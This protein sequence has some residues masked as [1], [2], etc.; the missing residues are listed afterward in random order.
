[1]D[2]THQASR[3]HV[4]ER[5]LLSPLRELDAGT[6]PVA[7]GK[8]ANLGELI[9][10]GFP[11]PDGFCLTTGAYGELAAAAGLTDVLVRLA[12]LA[13]AAVDGAA[14]LASQARERILATPVPAATAAAVRAAYRELGEPSVAVRSSATAEDLPSASFAGQ[15]DT[16]LEI[17]GAD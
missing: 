8:A 9:R 11:V 17:T 16:Y 3:Q 2:A 12:A 14:E 6:L 7:G 15:Q 10:A 4:F 1:M 13:P 5:S